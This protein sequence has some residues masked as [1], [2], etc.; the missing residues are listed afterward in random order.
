[1]LVLFRVKN[2][3]SFKDE[4]ILDMRA[5]NY[6]QHPDH[7]I[8][9]SD[10]TRLLKTVSIYGAN[11]SGKSNLI[12]A[13]YFM[14]NYITSQFYPKDKEYD[15]E[16]SP[17]IRNEPFILCDENEQ[18]TEFEIQFISNERFH[19]YGFS[20]GADD[21]VTEEYLYIDKQKVFERKKTSI[22]YGKYYRSVIGKYK[23][24]SSKRLYVPLLDYFLDDKASEKVLKSFK[25]FF[26]DDFVLYF[27][28]KFEASIK[29]TV[30]S[31]IAIF[32]VI[33][34]DE[35]IRNIVLESMQI[36]DFSITGIKTRNEE[37]RQKDGTSQIMTLIELEHNVYDDDGNVCGSRVLPLEL[38][39]S[40][41]ISFLQYMEQVCSVLYDG[42]VFVVDE[43]SSNLHPKLT[44]FI[45]DLFQT[46]VN[47]NAQLIFTTHDI[48][49]LNKDQF[50]RDEIVFVDKDV[51]GC[52]TVY[53]LSDLRVREDASFGK[54][55]MMGKYGA[56]PII[57]SELDFS[58]K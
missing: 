5:T 32:Q 37:W 22:S 17:S 6:V 41:T 9:M 55:Y 7:V 34:R 52:S 50:R 29:Q 16:K 48:S 3:A 38:E 23:K 25:D 45:V 21:E 4:V 11:A 13:L 27:T 31:P 53:S 26:Y 39:S 10:D 35:E 20:I 42:G 12:R 28:L 58:R 54:E 36:A 40:G 30:I 33:N 15:D 44:K 18:P 56:I 47:K 19:V 14:D 1:M 43:M 2:F 24:V 51:K 8:E 46:P 57:N 49:L